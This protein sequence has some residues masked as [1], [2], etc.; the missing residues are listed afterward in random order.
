MQD[1]AW[2]VDDAQV[3]EKLLALLSTAFAVSPVV[4]PARF[5]LVFTTT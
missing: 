1:F 4:P 5:P 2:V 3:Q